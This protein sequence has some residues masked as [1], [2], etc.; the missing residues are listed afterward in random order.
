MEASGSEEDDLDKSREK[1]P[2]EKTPR[3]ARNTAK[4]ISCD[5]C[6]AKY[7]RDLYACPKCEATNPRFTMEYASYRNEPGSKLHCLNLHACMMSVNVNLNRSFSARAR[8]N[9]S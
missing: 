7:D 8:V 2:Q 5:E 1:T 6:D 3:N 9:S 4:T